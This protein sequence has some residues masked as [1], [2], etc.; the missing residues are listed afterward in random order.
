[1][2]KRVA[3]LVVVVAAMGCGS[4]RKGYNQPGPCLE[5]QLDC[6]NE[7]PCCVVSGPYTNYPV[8]CPSG[9]HCCNMGEGAVCYEQCPTKC[10]GDVANYCPVGKWCSFSYPSIYPVH[11]GCISPMLGGCSED[12]PPEARCG[13]SV[14]CG[15]G[16]MC[17]T[18]A[19]WPTHCCVALAQ[20]DAGTD[21][22]PDAAFEDGPADAPGDAGPG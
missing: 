4:G 7:G 18:Q 19:A 16:T 21:A 13:D 15:P 10:P 11:S 17:V 6:S 14:C 8:C 12:C 9:W 5:N 2:L 3:A 22:P 1:M 20:A